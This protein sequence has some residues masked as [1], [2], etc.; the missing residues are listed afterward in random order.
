MDSTNIIS[1]Y[2]IQGQN[3]AKS[4]KKVYLVENFKEQRYT[5]YMQ[6]VK[7]LWNRQYSTNFFNSNFF[8]RVHESLR[9][10][11]S[12]IAVTFDKQNISRNF[13][14]KKKKKKKIW[15][16]LKLASHRAVERLGV[17]VLTVDGPE[18]T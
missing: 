2:H 8:N 6:H 4:C 9:S 17:G 5:E 16:P 1:I 7:Y 10:F 15:P 12:Q 14:F 3:L 11:L 18:H 13:H